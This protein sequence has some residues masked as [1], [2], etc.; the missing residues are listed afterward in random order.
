MQT[1]DQCHYLHIS[2]KLLHKLTVLSVSTDIKVWISPDENC[3]RSAM[4]MDR[5]CSKNISCFNPN[6]VRYEYIQSQVVYCFKNEDAVLTRN[7]SDE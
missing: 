5:H 1:K 4:L 3:D 2:W 7:I 6:L